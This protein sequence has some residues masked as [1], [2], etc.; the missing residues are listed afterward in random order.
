M[1]FCWFYEFV[2]RYGM[3]NCDLLTQFC[4]ILLLVVGNGNKEIKLII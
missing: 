2:D 1:C 3:E 4:M